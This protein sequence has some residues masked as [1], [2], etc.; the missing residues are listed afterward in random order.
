MNELID[1]PKFSHRAASFF[2][3]CIP[4]PHSINL[5]WDIVHI[6]MILLYIQHYNS[7]FI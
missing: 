5:A 1:S 4:K 3:L 6:Y 7:K 2:S